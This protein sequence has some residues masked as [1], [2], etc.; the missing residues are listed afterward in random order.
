M[1]SAVKSLETKDNKNDIAAMTIAVIATK[2]G[3]LH[4]DFGEL[5]GALKEMALAISKIALVEERQ[6][7]VA[8][9]QE[10]INKSIEKIEARLG[11]L[12]QKVPM[13]DRTSKWVDGILWSSAG[14]AV[15][16]ILNKLKMLP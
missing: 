9:V 13:Q 6:H 4:D 14:L 1:L 8:L 5:K 10:S 11:M 3:H 15:M 16:F 12:E 7:Q 2:L